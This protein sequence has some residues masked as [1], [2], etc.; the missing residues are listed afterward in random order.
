[1]TAFKNENIFILM[2]PDEFIKKSD[3]VQFSFLFLF[4]IPSLSALSLDLNN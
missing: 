2:K 4:F 1:M 3:E